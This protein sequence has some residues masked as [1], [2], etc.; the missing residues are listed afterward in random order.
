MANNGTIE[1]LLGAGAGW[2]RMLAADGGATWRVR[3]TP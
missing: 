1:E 3:S 2:A